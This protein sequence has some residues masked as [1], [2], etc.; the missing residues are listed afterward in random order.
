[1]AL[2]IIGIELFQVETQGTIAR[3]EEITLGRYSFNYRDL[4]VFDTEDGRNVARAVIQVK[5][6]GR[7]WAEMYPR[8]DYYYESQQPV[9]VP[10]VFSSLEEDIYVVLVDW[11]PISSRGATFKVYRNPL[12]NWLWLGS[13]VFLIGTLVASWPVTQLEK[14]RVAHL[15]GKSSSKVYVP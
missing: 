14:D 4:A 15:T 11:Q 10:G 9:T 2:G 8:R 3:G 7:D 1:M 5:L 13:F 6:D 12:I